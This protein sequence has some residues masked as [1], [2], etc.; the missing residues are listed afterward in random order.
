MG[1]EES[2]IFGNGEGSAG[3]FPFS[4]EGCDCLVEGL[5]A[6]GGGA[7]DGNCVVTGGFVGEGGACE[8]GGGQEEAGESGSERE[9][10]DHDLFPV[11][12]EL[13]LLF[14][15]FNWQGG[16]AAWFW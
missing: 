14:A 10:S 2:A 11:F 13:F 4:H 16:K 6:G 15:P 3:D 7:G 1:E 8:V 12:G 5:R 9:V